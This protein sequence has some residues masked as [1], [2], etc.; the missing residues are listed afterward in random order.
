M[1]RSLVAFLLLSLGA[2]NGQSTAP[3][4]LANLRLRWSMG[5]VVAV[6]DS[7]DYQIVEGAVTMSEGDRFR[8]CAEVV[9]EC[10]LY[11]VHVAPSGA[12]TALHPV[13]PVF[14]GGVGDG[15]EIL[16]PS[17]GRWFTLDAETGIER[18]YLVASVERQEELERALATHAAASVAGQSESGAAV[19]KLL[20]GLR[21]S[22]GNFTR[23]AEKPVSIAGVVRGAENE[24][25][26]VSALRH[27]PIYSAWDL[28]VKT[29]T[30]D[31]R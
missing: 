17:G 31:H 9:L 10:H 11:V 14:D 30:I 24:A 13:K 4:S 5:A 22:T 23:S 28:Y 15:R 6:G 27:A 7:T 16:L 25:Q 20:L 1:R 19:R 12:V 18:I 29:L 26:C 2:V 21:R 8:L 3:D